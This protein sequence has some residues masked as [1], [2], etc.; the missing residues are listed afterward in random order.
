MECGIESVTEEGRKEMHKNCRIGTDR[1]GELLIHARR[2][3]PWV[4]ANLIKTVK[5]DPRQVA[6]WQAQL[7]AEGVWV[8]EPVP[9]F[10]F[11]G[12][13]QYVETFGASTDDSAWERA[14]AYYLESFAKSG[15]SDIQDQRPLPLS[16]LE[17]EARA[18][19]F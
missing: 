18:C 19:V 5:D 9:M 2:R 13:E 4:Q 1:I 8:S 7:K 15:F 14:H 11:P 16:E 17:S 3:I 12:S 6:R 10:P